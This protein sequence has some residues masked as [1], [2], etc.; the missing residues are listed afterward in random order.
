MKEELKNK[1][2]NLSKYAKDYPE[3]WHVIPVLEVIELIEHR[4][5][6]ERLKEEEK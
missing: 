6:M 2:W 1:L 3:H 5:L 4:E